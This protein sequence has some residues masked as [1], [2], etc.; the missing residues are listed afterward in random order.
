MHTYFHDDQIGIRPFTKEDIEPLMLAVRAS[1]YELQPYLPWCHPDY[2][3]REARDWVYSRFEAWRKNA[4]FDFVV[5]ERET[6]ELLGGVGLNLIYYEHRYGNLGYW[7]RTD[8][9]GR[10]YATRAAWLAI[11]FAFEEVGLNRVEIAVAM[12]NI[13]SQR[14]AEKIG[15]TREGILRKRLVLHGVAHD[16][17]M[18]SILY[19]DNP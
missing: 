4:E 3:L 18:Y 14:V 9:A 16:M 15:A 19:N 12:D 10:G 5:Y 11:Q 13:P 1:G 6:G 7:I 8:K 2:S 17:L